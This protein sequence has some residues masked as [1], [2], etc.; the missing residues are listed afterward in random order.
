MT[1][2]L[3]IVLA[4]AVLYLIARDHRREAT[5]AHVEQALAVGNDRPE[6]RVVVHDGD[7][8]YL[9]DQDCWTDYPRGRR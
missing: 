7:A 4:A 6:V 1:T 5:E 3:T 2:A 8:G 9:G